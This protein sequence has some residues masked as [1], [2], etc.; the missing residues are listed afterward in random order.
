MAQKI[1]ATQMFGYVLEALGSLSTTDLCNLSLSPHP[2]QPLR[3]KNLEDF[4]DKSART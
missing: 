4:K 3:P 1:R 2:D